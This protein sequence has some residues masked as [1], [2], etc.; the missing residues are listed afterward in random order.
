MSNYYTY[1]KND[2]ETSWKRYNN[3]E[4][5]NE[6][7]YPNFTKIGNKYFVDEKEIIFMKMLR[8]LYK[9]IMMTQ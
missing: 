2:V 3:N 7:K 6:K 4:E 8:I 5:I 9:V 1:K